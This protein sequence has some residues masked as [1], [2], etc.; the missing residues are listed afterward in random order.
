MANRGIQ[1][2]LIEAALAKFDE[3]FRPQPDWADWESQRTH[4]FAIQF[5]QQLY[6]IEKILSLVSDLPV[7]EFTGGVPANGF[8]VAHGFVLKD[9]RESPAMEF[10]KGE[11]YDRRTEIHSPFGGSAQHGI[12]PS[13]LTKAIFLF[14]GASGEQFGYHDAEGTDGVYSY[15]GEGQVGEMTMDNSRNAAIRDHAKTG[16]ALHLFRSMGKGKGQRY[17]GEFSCSS[18]SKELGLDRDGKKRSIIKF[19]LV[20]VVSPFTFESASES[21]EQEQSISTIPLPDLRKIALE[22][23]NVSESSGSSTALR[24]I[25]YRSKKVKDYVLSRAAGKCESCHKPAPFTSKS[26]I[27]YLEPHHIDRLSDGGVDHPQY[28]GAVCP[29]CHREIHFGADGK[30]KNEALRAAIHNKEQSAE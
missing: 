8:L 19:H 3:H 11:V 15:T 16:R 4:K 28:V 2:S 29:D 6:P 24:T 1:I 7:R 10:I 13:R 9:L 12:A 21:E 18:F 14:A 17:V 23:A 27:P 22:A 5:E 26:G 30:S 25:Y 20:P